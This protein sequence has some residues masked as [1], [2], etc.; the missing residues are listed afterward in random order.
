MKHTRLISL[1]LALA[2]M[3]GLSIPATA[4][5]PKARKALASL[6]SV[7]F[8][9]CYVYPYGTTFDAT[10]VA[11][12]N[13]T[14]QFKRDHA[15]PSSDD[16]FCVGIYDILSEAL[17]EAREYKMSE[18]S[19]P[20]YALGM[21]WIADHRYPVGDYV[22]VCFVTNKD[23]EVYDQEYYSAVLHVVQAEVSA[24]SMSLYRVSDGY[25]DEF[26]VENIYWE[27][28][29]IAPALEPYYNTQPRKITAT[30]SNP[31][32]LSV[33]VDAGYVRLEPKGYGAVDVTITC[34][35]FS[36]TMW[37]I[38]GELE[39]IT[40]VP[41]QTSLCVGMTDK[42]NVSYQPSDK[43]VGA[44]WTTS[45][46]SVVTVRDGIVTA[47]GPGEAYVQVT[48][49][50]RIAGMNYEVHYHDLPE[51]TPVSTRT[52]TQPACAV[53]H[54][55][56]CGKD[57]CVNVYE[58][59]IFR[60]TV[61]DS[62][63]AEHVDFVYDNKLMNG[64]SEDAFA[65]NRPVTR[66]MAVTV[67]YRIAG[68]P[69]VEGE[70]PF[71]DVAEDTWYT[72]AIT[73]AAENHILNGV[74]NHLCKPNDQI[75]REQFAAILYRYTGGEIG[76][77]PVD[78]SSFPDDADVSAYAKEAMVW[79]VEEGLITGVAS[80]GVNY[81]MPRNTMTRAQFATI[82]SRHLATNES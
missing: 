44:V 33:S 62:W 39:S 79:A 28:V 2:L 42:V 27:P 59:A 72:D 49:G 13:R 64:V 3:L 81:L 22:L 51:G 1:L 14:L 7:A 80:N 53:G 11:G 71:V 20:D 56:I 58:N 8:G 19:A 82:I 25:F 70:N 60:D 65:P 34:D 35:E 40:A 52:A 78:L 67:L 57:N 17:I 45:D 68:E 9:D 73:W 77:E 29:T 10:V 36:R 21:S 5:Q 69:E 43:P 54:C 37:L 31:E 47:V 16:I 38:S 66:A 61:A 4:A 63:Y 12:G 50:T 30:S 75:T 55:S 41:T 26:F 23:G 32:V 46:P 15:S 76:E 18:F 24:Q 74:G 48:V 6:K